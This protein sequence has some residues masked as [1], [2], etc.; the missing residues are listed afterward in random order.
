MLDVV[1]DLSAK[2]KSFSLRLGLRLPVL[3]RIEQNYPKDIQ[4]CLMEALGEW[5]K[6][7]YDHNK[8]G[9]PSWRRLAEA[10]RKLGFYSTFEAI[11][12]EHS[13]IW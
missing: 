2:W 10:A 12:K 6:L 9:K 13:V 11:V 3:D 7:N 4:G 8:R 5:L 1:D